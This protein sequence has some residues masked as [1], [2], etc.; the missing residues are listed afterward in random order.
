MRTPELVGSAAARGVHGYS[1][2]GEAVVLGPTSFPAE[3]DAGLSRVVD[4]FGLSVL[5]SVTS[6]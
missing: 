1:A 2:G 3:R 5:G 6:G 4:L